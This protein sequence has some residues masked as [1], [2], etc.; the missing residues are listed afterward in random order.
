M[1]AMFNPKMPSIPQA[2][3]V[4]PTINDADVAAKTEAAMK[5][6]RLRQGRASTFLTDPKAQ[7][8]AQANAQTYLTGL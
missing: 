5:N 6:E 8:T 1:A 3:P 7:R 4:A 2:A